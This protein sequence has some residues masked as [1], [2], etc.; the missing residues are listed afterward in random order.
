[1]EPCDRDKGRVCTKEGESVPIVERRKR[2]S[3]GVC[4]RTVKKGVY[5]AIKVTA[6]GASIFCGK[7][8]QEEKD[9]VRLQVSK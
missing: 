9:G 2:E 3:K 8:G 6:N 4:S 1:M 5:P 7:E